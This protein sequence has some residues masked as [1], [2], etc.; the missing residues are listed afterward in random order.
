MSVT[1]IASAEP[2]FTNGL[3]DTSGLCNAT[4]SNG[5][6]PKQIPK[7]LEEVILDYSYHNPAHGPV[8]I[9]LNLKLKGLKSFGST[10]NDQHNVFITLTTKQMTKAKNNE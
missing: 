1:N 5:R 6:Q 9:S 3:A 7:E 4:R 2:P 8:S 10:K